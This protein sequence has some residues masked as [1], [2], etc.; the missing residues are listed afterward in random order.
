MSNEMIA[1]VAPSVFASEPHESR[2]R[3]SYSFIPTAVVLEGMR[4]EGF[5]P[6]YASQSR[7]RIAGKQEFTRHMLRFR[8]PG[9]QAREVGDSVPE[10]VLLNSHDGTSSYQVSAGLYRLVCSN[11]MMVSSS[12]LQ[13]VRIRHTK[14]VVEDVI[15]GSF[16]VVKE[17]PQ[18]FDSIDSM[19]HVQLP[20]PAQQAFAHA[21]A[22]LRWGKD[23]NIP[24]AP[25]RL[26]AT[27]RV[28]DEGSDLWRVFNRV[29]ENLVKGGLSARTAEGKRTSTRGINS[30][31]AD[32]KL[33]RD[34]WELAANVVAQIG[35]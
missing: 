22:I 18:L 7:T 2:R 34:L 26:L 33:N 8:M 11:G 16:S 24:V 27:R 6:V 25:A 12:V 19:R 9:V 4:K 28:V 1:R 29:Q 30:V 21:A 14:Q 32:V 31:N 17:L 20:E 3:D 10:I 35:D 15:E 5:V 13:D 23:E